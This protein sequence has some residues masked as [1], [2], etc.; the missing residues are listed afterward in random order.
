MPTSQDTPAGPAAADVARALLTT[1]SEAVVAAD[2]DGVITVWNPGAE[3]LFG[4]PVEEAVGSTL[5]LIVPER[6][7]AAHWRGYREVMRTGRS[8]YG[9][10]DVLAVP[11]VRRG[12]ATVSLEF[13]VTPLQDPGGRPAGIVAV[14]RDVTARFEELR[15]LRRQL[16]APGRAAGGS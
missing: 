3:R 8:R 1:S 7:R 2:R 9:P 10:G 11:G 16:A 15:A 14:L 12:G 5:D 13:T 4:H 6:L